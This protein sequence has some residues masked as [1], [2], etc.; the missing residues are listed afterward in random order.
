MIK[1]SLDAKLAAALFVLLVVS[2]PACLAQLA[3]LSKGDVD[4]KWRSTQINVLDQQLVDASPESQLRRELESQKKWLTEWVPGE[5]GTEALW[6]AGD[7]S[8]TWT[9]PVIDPEGRA[10]TLRARLLGPQAK[11]TK[12][13]TLALQR[14]LKEYPQDI[15]VRQLH[16]HWLDQLVY[17]KRY[18][19]EIAE[20]AQG[21]RA[22][23]TASRTQNRETM[24]ARAFCLYREGRALA[25]R[26]LPDVIRERPIEDPEG[27]EAKLLGV[28]AQLRELAGSGRPEFILLEIRMLRRDNWFGQALALL[29]ANGSKITPQWFLKKRRDLL[30]ELG[31][32]AAFEE[33][34]AIYA[35]EFP[36]AVEKEKEAERNSSPN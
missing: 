36:D 35:K 16:L 10:R 21:V 26:E 23:L 34:A 9:E 19:D 29:E 5:L 32:N 11:P 8:P 28:F 15:G 31:W 22:L 24:R 6:T 13:D 1:R 14:L 12:Q 17:R 25:Y 27:H 20:S 33:A 30:E 7:E 3:V 4:S 2:A 18:A